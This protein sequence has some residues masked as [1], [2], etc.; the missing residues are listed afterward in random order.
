MLEQ[1][2][3]PTQFQM[4]ASRCHTFPVEPSPL[5]RSAVRWSQHWA[6][7]RGASPFT[8][9]S[10]LTN[11]LRTYLTPFNLLAAPPCNPCYSTNG[12]SHICCNEGDQCG[13]ALTNGSPTCAPVIGALNSETFTAVT[14]AVCGSRNG[15]KMKYL[16]PLARSLIAW[17]NHAPLSQTL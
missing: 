3:W 17:I 13:P 14:C 16:D 2:H 8:S 12:S 6:E 9:R 5:M 1:P 10:S 15:V 11:F 4:Q 7:A